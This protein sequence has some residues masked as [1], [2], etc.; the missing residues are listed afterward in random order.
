MDRYFLRLPQISDLS[1]IKRHTLN[2]R[3]KSQINESEIE[4]T[5]GNQII[6]RPQQTLEILKPNLNISRGKII[7]TGNL[8]GGVGKTTLAYL[9]TETLVSFGLKVCTID[10]DVQANLTNQYVATNTDQNVF[11]DVIEKKIAISDLPI[12]ITNNFD[13]IPSSLRN[14]LIQKALTMQPAQHLRN[15][16]NNLCLNYLRK[17][18][19]IIIVDTP[20]HLSTLNSVF[21]LCLGE[22]DNI[23][24][25]VAPEEFSILGVKMFLDDIVD[26]RH[27]F[28]VSEEV[29]I[30][31]LMNRFFQTQKSNL[32][33]LV[34][35]TELYGELFSELILRDFSKIREMMNQKMSISEIKSGKEIYEFIQGLLSDI[36]LIKGDDDVVKT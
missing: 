27:S 3:I 36:G 2:A 24:I 9:L 17:H 19:D 8:K 35:M 18:Y 21:C 16:F 28:D 34:K 31:V 5:P 25:P 22:R 1:G 10:L 6:L 13:L 15:W 26:I 12:Q 7:F 4:R 20:P 32:E 30:K 29:N 33:I 23:I 11:L 14:S